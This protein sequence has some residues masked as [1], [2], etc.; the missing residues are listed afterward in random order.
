[1]R[2]SGEH[3]HTAQC[4]GTRS[5]TRNPFPTAVREL[6]SHAGVEPLACYVQVGIP[7]GHPPDHS[8][9]SGAPSTQHAKANKKSIA[10]RH[11]LASTLS[12]THRSAA[13]SSATSV[14]LPRV[15]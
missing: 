11:P 9:L 8:M 13:P 7:L 14:R 12:P 10:D 3:L 15:A 2:C 1:M 4:V 6:L 5:L